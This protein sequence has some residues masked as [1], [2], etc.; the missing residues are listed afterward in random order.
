VTDSVNKTVLT[1]LMCIESETHPSGTVIHCDWINVRTLWW[2][3]L[4]PTVEYITCPL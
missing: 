2:T 1:P 3:Q 4:H